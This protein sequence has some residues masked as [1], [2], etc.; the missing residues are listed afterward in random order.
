MGTLSHLTCGDPTKRRVGIVN[1]QQMVATGDPTGHERCKLSKKQSLQCEP[2][3]IA[4]ALPLP[5]PLLPRPQLREGRQVCRGLAMGLVSTGSA[6]EG[7]K[8]QS[9]GSPSSVQ[10]CSRQPLPPSLPTQRPTAWR[11]GERPLAWSDPRSGPAGSFPLG[12]CKEGHLLWWPPG[13]GREARE[14]RQTGPVTWSIGLSWDGSVLGREAGGC[15]DHSWWEGIPP[16][17]GGG[18]SAEEA[19]GGADPGTLWPQELWVP[20]WEGATLL[21]R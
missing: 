1:A 6:I 7:A 21:H 19:E 15:G 16:S 20:S 5:R 17:W 13:R 14:P 2:F 12:F 9:T 18:G 8:L 3:L 4:P 10:L 11:G